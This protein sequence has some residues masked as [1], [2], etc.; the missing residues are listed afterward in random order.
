MIALFCFTQKGRRRR[1]LCFVSFSTMYFFIAYC[2]C[3]GVSYFDFVI[4][5]FYSFIP[6]CVLPTY[7]TIQLI[8]AI[9]HGSYCTYLQ[10]FQQKVFNFDKINESFTQKKIK[11]V[12]YTT[13]HID[14]PP[15]TLPGTYIYFHKF[16]VELGS[17]C[18]DDDKC[19]KWT[20]V[21]ILTDQCTQILTKSFLFVWKQG[22]K[23]K[24]CI[25]FHHSSQ[26]IQN[27]NTNNPIQRE[28]GTS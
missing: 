7:F 10:Y 24:N 1:Q 17:T 9:I 23:F 19:P 13:Q 12:M 25:Y 15:C 3:L 2:L 14:T 11:K 8:F 27:K 20:H 26:G 6:L 22:R 28:I 21:I 16:S 18:Q 5:S 4:L